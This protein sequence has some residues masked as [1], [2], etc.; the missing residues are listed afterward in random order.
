MCPPL[1]SLRSFLVTEC[2]I[3]GGATDLSIRATERM[4]GLGGEFWYDR[5]GSCGGLQ[6]RDIPEDLHA[7][8]PD[9]YYAFATAGASP[10]GVR[11]RIRR[12]R[13]ALV[14]GGGRWA[15]RW[16]EPLLSPGML[17]LRG[18]LEAAQADRGSRIL[19]VGCGD[20]AWLRRLR[21]QGFEHVLGVDPFIAN[22]IMHAGRL[23]VAKGT[24]DDITG[25]WDL[26]MFHHSLE[27]IADQRGTLARVAELLAPR[28]CC[29]IRI[30]TVSS[31]AWEEFRDRWVQ[32]DAPRHLM[33]HSTR[34][35]ERLADAVG[36]RVD[37]VVY[38]STMF[39]FE[40]SELYRRDRPLTELSSS[41]YTR[42]QRRRFAAKAAALNA[43]GRG[44]QAAFYLRHR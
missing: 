7:F 12:V 10:G 27:H 3:C 39:Q 22:P 34:S 19:D 6:L 44:D 28:G 8:Y 37:A 2:R 40:G 20:G 13:D 29:L 35:L 38:D 43:E 41:T 24:L 36:L 1:S 16:I 33:L 23:L 26:M 15:T 11:A 4:F 42:R 9:N 21:D 5:C 31:Y 18:W 17:Q 30:P 25:E 32:L 14:F